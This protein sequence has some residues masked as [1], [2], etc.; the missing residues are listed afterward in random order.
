MEK[1]YVILPSCDEQNK[2]DQALLFETIRL[3]KDSGNIGK[4]YVVGEFKNLN[5]NN[6]S[7]SPLVPLL[8]HPSTRYKKNNYINYSLLVKIK[9]GFI[10][11]LDLII[12][13]F[14]LNRI[15]EKIMYYF[16]NNYRKKTIDIFDEASVFFIKGGGF[17]HSEGG[18]TSLYKMYFFLYHILY[19]KKR[20]KKIVF[21]PN[22]FGPF[23]GPFVKRFVKYG[24]SKC[25]VI[26][27]R[28]SISQQMLKNDCNLNSYL[29]PDL[30]FFLQPETNDL[31]NNLSLSK[32]KKNV[33]ITV[34]PYR[35]NNDRNWKKLYNNYKVSFIKF[36]IWLIEHNYNPIL[37]EQ[38]YSDVRHEQDNYCI[39]EITNI[40]KDKKYSINI[41][42]TKD[43]TCHEVKYI[44]SQFNYTIGTRFH[45]VIFSLAS[46]VPS[47]AITYGGNKGN[48]IMQDMN[49]SDYTISIDNIS[50]EYLLEKFNLLVKNQDK[51]TNNL[52]LKLEDYSNE[53]L[54]MIKVIEEVISYE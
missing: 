11:I 3:A 44:Y 43:L 1:L 36:I 34:R 20:N 38:V 31:F 49:L 13:L 32:M 25:D 41:I 15:F 8:R 53:R 24:L 46:Y 35:F 54:K 17:I 42:R 37:V 33:A 40:L 27:C 12:S 21:M 28:E 23:N 10:A 39:M 45:S 26:M 16:S 30:G 48:G 5:I 7:Y 18:F 52:S 2:G 51:Y 22:S 47:I 6:S 19:A 50:F 29:F 14:M 4:Y 9:W